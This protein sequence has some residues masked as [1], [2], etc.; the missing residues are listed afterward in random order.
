MNKVELK[1]IIYCYGVSA[2]NNV[3][4]CVKTEDG[5]ENNYH[6]VLA[7]L[8]RQDIQRL[9][10]GGEITIEGSLKSTLMS[11]LN[12]YEISIIAKSVKI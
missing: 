4:I 10:V 2:D 12:K 1:G 3:E 6:K 5:N 7:L 8:D 9:T 11:S